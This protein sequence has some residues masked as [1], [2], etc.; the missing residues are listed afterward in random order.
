MSRYCAVERLGPLFLMVDSLQCLHGGLHSLHK[1][2]PSHSPAACCASS[3]RPGV[4]PL[5]V[6]VTDSSPGAVLSKKA[7]THG[8]PHTQRHVA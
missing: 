8:G 7:F 5:A 6:L 1:H 4:T 2:L 3:A